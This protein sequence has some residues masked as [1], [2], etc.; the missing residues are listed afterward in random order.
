MNSLFFHVLNEQRRHLPL[1]GETEGCQQAIIIKTELL[2]S[3][4]VFL[5]YFYIPFNRIS[6][7]FQRHFYLVFNTF[8]SHFIQSLINVSSAGRRR[9]CPTIGGKGGRE[10]VE[11]GKTWE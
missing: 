11:L 4:N 1:R 6:K 7:T 8:Q 5:P 10:K 3:Y 2:L 9:A